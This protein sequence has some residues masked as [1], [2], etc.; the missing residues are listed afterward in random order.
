MNYTE[1]HA[2]Y[3][4]NEL[5]RRNSCSTVEKLSMSLFDATVDLN[6][7]QVEAALFAFRSPISKGVILADEVGLG[8]TI[9]AGLVMC[10]YWAERKRKI[11]VICPS[12]LRKQW[13]IELKEKFNLPSTILETKTYNDEKKNGSI[14][15]FEQDKV[16][17]V[18]THFANRKK[19]D[20]RLVNWDLVVIDEAHKLRNVY[21]K[22][23]K[24]GNGIRWAVEDKKKILLTATPLQN[25]LLELYGLSVLIDE[26][27]FGDIK[28]FRSQFINQGE[29]AQLKERLK[30]FTHRTL[31]KDVL[32]YI[33]Y[34]ERHPLT[35]KFRATDEEYELYEKVSEF[36]QREDTY[37]IPKS[38]RT[39]TTLILRKLLAS[40]TE[41]I[42]GTLKTIKDR[43]IKIKDGFE[44]ESN[45]FEDYIDDEDILCQ[46]HEDNEDNEDIEN[47]NIGLQ[48]RI[49]NIEKIENEIKE[50]EKFISL[51][52]KIKIDTKSNALL[53][54]IEIGFNK[55]EDMG[56][57]RKALIFT[58]SRRTQ[59]YIKNFLENSGYKDK[60]V[61]FNGTNTCKEARNIYIEWLENNKNTGKI[62]G[63][64]SADKRASLIEYFRDKAEIM[65]ATESAAEGVNLQFCSLIIN[66]DLPWNPQRIE[67]RIGRCHRYGQK[68]DVV[69]VNFLNERNA[70]DRRV[71]ELLENKF[72][73]FKGVLGSSDEVLGSLESGVDF[74][75]RILNIYQNCRNPEDIEREFNLLQKEMEQT[76]NSKMEET[77]KNLLDN[78][79]EDVH[80]RLKVQLDKAKLFL[81]RYEKLFWRLTKY[82]LKNFAEF[83]DEKLTFN[84]YKNIKGAF[85]KGNYKLISKD[86]NKKNIDGNYLY[87]ISHPI[88]EYVI[89]NALKRDLKKSKLIFDITN[90][91]TKISVIEQL[92]GK[93]G[94][95]I[96]SKFTIDSFEREEYLLFNGY[97]TSGEIL[98]P[99]VCKKLFECGASVDKSNVTNS[100]EERLLNDSKQHAR[101]ILNEVMEI[102]QKYF[103]EEQER[104]YK[105]EEDMILSAEKALE[106]TKAQIKLLERQARRAISL[107]EQND[108][109][110]KIK[111]LERLKRK[112]RRDIFDIEDDVKQKREELIEALEKRM[113]HKTNLETLFIIDFEV[114]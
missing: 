41:A 5:I 46:L 32:E 57:N 77:K 82:E 83:E 89:N 112:Q 99:E 16:M 29:I 76:I 75:R 11:L 8:K 96:L 94:S 92:K 91:R 33:K 21:K 39:L 35:Q 55:L 14:N 86:K 100:Y 38:Q 20:I 31:R 73:L 47:D 58:E 24:M 88:G 44:T 19:E 106:D 102:N 109:N 70:A 23:N 42:I 65:I 54:A 113:E 66:Y 25:S 74:E 105:W 18:S 90:H 30:T 107:K 22:N 59:E 68:H 69:V 10:Q 67:Q 7:H 110:K 12:S 78:F 3:Y 98:P 15:P 1:Y 34:T 97:L 40:S 114:K 26:H 79:D 61:V 17:I 71:Y 93:S 101:A 37:A 103:L 80:L 72:N 2:K 4:A 111:E 81:D 63:S 48:Q 6:P 62:S 43:L 53:K 52:R 84:L 51:A 95:L 45:L 60:I 108:L 64:K 50:I 87:R 36:L 49:I 9:E 85:V 104:F 28:S 56:A 13:S 27:I